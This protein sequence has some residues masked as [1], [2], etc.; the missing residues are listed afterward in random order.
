MMTK[1][2]KIIAACSI[3]ALLTS[4]GTLDDS[5]PGAALSPAAGVSGN[6]ILTPSATSAPE[7]K[8]L[9]SMDE[10]TEIARKDANVD[11][12][13]LED[14]HARLQ[15][16]DSGKEYFVTFTTAEKAYQYCI[17][18]ADGM[19][20]E[21]DVH[22]VKTAEHTPMPEKP[23]ESTQAPSNPGTVEASA[24]VTPAAT[25]A[26][27]PTKTASAQTKGISQESALEI[28]R[29][30][31]G[32]SEGEIFNL[33]IDLDY[34]DG[35][36]VYEIEF[37]TA[38]TE[39]DYEIAVSDGRIVDK[40]TELRDKILSS[41]QPT[42]SASAQ[43][44]GISQE[45]ALEIARTDAG[46]SEGE[47]FNLEIDLDYEDGIKVYEIEFDTASTEYDYEIA[48]SDGR[49]VDKKTELRDKILS[50]PQPTKSASAQTDEITQNRALEI[51]K[52]DAGISAG[53]LYDLEIGLDYDDGIRLYEIEFCHGGCEY[54]YEVCAWNGAILKRECDDCDDW[55]HSGTSYY[56]RGHGCNR[57]C[58]N[59]AIYGK[60]A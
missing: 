36:K 9:L 20:L 10:A 42:K 40:K 41:P 13:G 2:L 47:I 12:D 16:S 15:D 26:P 39:Y 54:E 32:V 35:I 24:T 38:S 7:D 1:N 25:A 18:A 52:A 27:Q 60:K 3:A 53:E 44:K 29:T 45:S 50:S 14:L 23:T 55:H 28:A 22:T 8:T 49:I 31:A 51:V 5:A 48:V 19:I 59:P 33:E 11:M 21:K 46:V 4:C 56:H 37:D 30:D 34:E 6:E 57:S 43:T 58:Y 17:S